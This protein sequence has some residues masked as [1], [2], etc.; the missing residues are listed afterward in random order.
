[1]HGFDDPKDP[2]TVKIIEEKWHA[3]I[4][5]FVRCIEVLL[6]EVNPTGIAMGDMGNRYAILNGLLAHTLDLLQRGKIK[7][8]SQ[9]KEKLTDNFI[10]RT[11]AQNHMIFGDPAVRLRIPI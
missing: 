7:N 1:M 6:R 11:D 5:P 4:R 10:F 2:D 9:F 8:T 3:R